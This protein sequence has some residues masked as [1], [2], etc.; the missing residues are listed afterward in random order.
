[1]KAKEKNID[2]ETLLAK[3]KRISKIRNC[4]FYVII[5]ALT[6]GLYGNSVLNYYSLDDYHVT[7]GNSQTVQGIKAIPDILTTLYA[8]ESGLSYGYRPLVRISFAIDHEL[9]GSMQQLPY[10]SHFINVLLYLI[11]IILL[12]NILKR[13]FRNYHAWFSFL[14][15]VLFLIHP[16]HTEVVASLKNRDEILAFLFAL[17]ALQQFMRWADKEKVKYLIFGSLFYM[18]ALLSKTTALSFLL[19]FPLSMY[20]FSDIKSKRLLIFAGVAVFATILAAAGPFIFLPEFSREIRFMEN[21]IVEEGFFTRV[22]TGFYVLLLYIKKL[23]FPLPMAYY[24]GY[25]M[26]PVKTYG[27]FWVILSVLIY[28]GMFIYA[29]KKFTQKHILSY[30]ILFFLITI[31]MFAN[32]VMPVPGIIGDRFMYYPSLAYAIILVFFLYKIFNTD[33][34]KTEVSNSKIISI[35]AVCALITI[36]YGAM[37][38]DR[39]KDWRTKYDLYEHDLTYLDNSVKAHD[40]FATE[41]IEQVSKDVFNQPVNVAKFHLPQIKKAINSYRRTLEIYPQQYSSYYN[42]GF[43]YGE[44]LYHDTAVSKAV[45]YYQKAIDSIQEY[46]KRQKANSYYYLGRLYR[47]INKLDSAAYYFNKGYEFSPSDPRFLSAQV[48]LYFEKGMDEKALQLNEK[49]LKQYPGSDEPYVNYGIY[50]FEK[51]LNNAYTYVFGCLNITDLTVE[52]LNTRKGFPYYFELASG[53]APIKNMTMNQILFRHYRDQ[54][55]WKFASFFFTFFQKELQQI[56]RQL[57]RR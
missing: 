13:L 33:V 45:Y 24:Y 21:P 10:I 57:E 2:Q 19:I 29:I 25:D 51:R 36:V 17:L 55:N 56:N 49:L 27:S 16:L 4:W 14:V 54:R 3:N 48:K 20:F 18:L 52:K 31:A 41:I 32:I 44:L 35:V 46:D 40:L 26:I 38:V 43:I 50:D 42:L 34:R 7:A 22:A 5:I 39:N 53:K 9:F 47:R 28:L 8:E 37:T 23:I 1:M 15:T 12:F 11:S 30:A 6:F